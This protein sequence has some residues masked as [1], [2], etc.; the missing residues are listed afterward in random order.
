[1]II[2]ATAS[3]FILKDISGVTR[4]KNEDKYDM[5]ILHL[6]CTIQTVMADKNTILSERKPKEAPVH[7]IEMTELENTEIS[8]DAKETQASPNSDIEDEI[9]ITRVIAIA[10]P[11][12]HAFV[13]FLVAAGMSLAIFKHAPTAFG[14]VCTGIILAMLV[15]ERLHFPSCMCVPCDY[16]K[17]NVVS[18]NRHDKA[19]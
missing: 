6:Q 1:M 8:V 19:E 7:E 10:P 18:Q 16:R 5:Y 12:L 13:L 17:G 4:G 9:S 2:I 11:A 3:E 14:L 15:D